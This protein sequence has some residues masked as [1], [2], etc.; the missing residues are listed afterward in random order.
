[1][2]NISANFNLHSTIQAAEQAFIAVSCHM[3]F[4]FAIHGLLLALPLAMIGILLSWRR[5]RFGAS[6]TRVAKKTSIFC[7]VLALPGIACLVIYGKLPDAG[8]FN[9]NSVGLVCLWS[10]IYLHLSAAQIFHSE[11]KATSAH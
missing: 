3:L 9:F 2:D 4:K 1:M 11:L 6:L 5:S 8:V 7:V 10:L